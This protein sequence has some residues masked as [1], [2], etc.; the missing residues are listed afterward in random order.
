VPISNPR[1]ILLLLLIAAVLYVI[2]GARAKKAFIVVVSGLYY[3]TFSPIYLAI[4]FVLLN[5]A[6][7]SGTW[8]NRV[9]DGRPR[10]GFLI[11]SIVLLIIPLSFFKYAPSV[12]NHLSLGGS[13]EDIV[14]GLLLPIGISFYTFQAIGY[15][16]DIYVRVGKSQKYL[17]FAAYMS[18][19]PQLTAGPIAR[20]VPFFKELDRLGIFDYPRFVAGLRY[21]LVG[22]FMKIV[23]ADNLAPLV[24]MVYSDPGKYGW[25]DLSLA[26]I[27]FSF[28]VYADFAGYSLIAIGA[29]RVLGIE[30]M[31]NFKQPY[32]SETLPEYWRT[33]HIS[34]S[35]WFRDYVFTPLH[36][37]LRSKGTAGL[38]IALLV[39]FTLVG[40]WHGAGAKYAIFGFI[41]GLLVALSTLTIKYRNRFA[42]TLP[43]PLWGVRIFRICATFSLVT[44]TFVIFRSGSLGDAQYIYDQILHGS[45][46]TSQLPLNWPLLLIA[47]LIGGDIL[48]RCRITFDSIPRLPRW[49]LYHGIALITLIMWLYNVGGDIPA[50]QQFIYYKF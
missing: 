24:S 36:L 8:M 26:T 23:I 9:P 25:D 3:C 27:F 12:A 49:V 46:M 43:I 50:S 38:V 42:A 4:L 20:S 19:F 45:V 31:T 39:T 17:D 32:L 16:C 7:I 10:L 13:F 44:A 41:H 2:P 40:I 48:A 14:H 21:V 47:L 1:F 33:W 28:Q 15:L 29:A 30:L 6:Y 37:S 18:F 11:V 34:L 5:I 35:S 22:S